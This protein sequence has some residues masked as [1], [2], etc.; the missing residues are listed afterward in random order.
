MNGIAPRINQIYPP[1]KAKQHQKP[2]NRMGKR[3][4][5]KETEAPGEEW[6]TM[7][8]VVT[9]THGGHHG[10]AVVASSQDGFASSLRCILV[11][12]LVREL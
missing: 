3:K 9:M 7:A 10:Q 6:A 2:K 11:L 12:V 1:F 5:A 8:V 4:A